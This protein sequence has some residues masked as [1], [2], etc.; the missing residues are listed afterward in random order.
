MPLTPPAKAIGAASSIP[1]LPISGWPLRRYLLVMLLTVLLPLLAFAGVLLWYDVTRQ[2]DI[3]RRGLLDTV[4][5][6][7]LAVD[8]EWAVLE[9]TMETLTSSPLLDTEDWQAFYNLCAR[10]ARRYPGAWIVLFAPSGEQVFNTLRPFGTALPNVFTEAPAMPPPQ[11]GEV[12]MANV[13]LIRR[14]FQTGTPGYSDLFRGF[15][16]QRLAISLSMP[17]Q[18]AGHVAYVLSMGLAPQMFARL[19]Q[20][21]GTPG[22][23]ISALVDRRGMTIARSH[24][25]EQFVGRPTTF[26]LPTNLTESGVGWGRGRTWEQIPVYYAW[27]RSTVTGWTTVISVTEASITRPIKRS[28]VLWGSGALFAFALA[29]ALALRVARCFTA[30]LAALTQS[31]DLLQQ[32][33]PF[34]M[35]L[36]AVQEIQ[37]LAA[38]LGLT[39]NALHQQAAERERRLLAEAEA[40]EHQRTTVVLAEANTALQRAEAAE[41]ELRERWETTLASIG[42]AVIVTDAAGRVTFLNPVAQTLTGWPVEAARERPLAAIFRLLNEHTRREVE[43]PVSR[44]LREG[45]VVGLA[46]HTIL[47]RPDGSEVPIDDSAAPIRNAQGTLLGVVLVFRDISARRRAETEH[48]QQEAAQRFLAG[49]SALLATSLDA[50]TQL[51]HMAQLL[52]PTLADWCSI[53]LLEED[54]CIHRVAVVHGDPAKAVLAEQLRQQYALLAV[55]TPHTLTRVLSTR[56]SWFDPAPSP[57]RLR[58]EARDQAHWDLI[59][60]LGFSA[61]IV[62]PLLARGRALG[63]IT[64]VL[65]EGSRRYTLAD[66]ALVEDLARRAALALDNARLYREAQAARVALQQANEDLEQRVTERTAALQRAME[67]R[68]HLE[69]EAQRAEHFAL[70]GRLAA[71]VSHELRNPL[72]AVFLHVDLLEE[73]LTQPSPESPAAISEALSA[74]K[75]HLGRVDDLMQDYLSLVRVHAIQCEVQ[76]LGA[77]VQA[78]GREFRNLLPTPGVQLQVE[79]TETLGK[80]AFHASTLRRA[81]LNLVQNAAEAMPHG[82]TI[83][84]AGQGTATQVQLQV[85]DTGSGIAAEHL[86]RLFEPLHTTKPGGTGLGLYIVQEVVSAHGGQVAVHSDVEHGTTFTITLPRSTGENQEPRN[87]ASGRH[88]EDSTTS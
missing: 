75:T 69:R 81:L 3:H 55:E 78:W 13:E 30:P 12:P 88:A 50:T 21:R 15:V 11:A 17:V 86:A 84:L 74:I 76:D 23:T 62:V 42:D 38:V 71:G 29:I 19:L 46:N 44:V 68:Q 39:V 9:A 48:T 35:P 56:Q 43:D 83:T 58:A 26:A 59:Q 72:G 47:L 14:T 25:A 28:L 33:K 54:G 4:Q 7:S 60:A 5:A 6:F 85:R 10:Q 1:G 67:E 65:G 27:Y 57:L 41:R 2:Y 82:G 53:D 61:E 40:A 34:T 66:L 52:V 31:A 70:L 20:E 45:L 8:R 16:A 49:A 80:V 87:V 73:E 22:E 79:G 37:H 32:G 24:N 64:C 77:A 36:A 63:T 51:T 18:R